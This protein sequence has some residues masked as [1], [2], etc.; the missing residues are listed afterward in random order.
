MRIVNTTISIGDNSYGFTKGAGEMWLLDDVIEIEGISLKSKNSS[1]RGI[2]SLLYFVVAVLIFSSI[3]WF[4]IVPLF[5]DI[6]QQWVGWF[7]EDP[8][9]TAIRLI[10]MVK[11][12][13]GFFFLVVVPLF[14]SFWLSDKIINPLRRLLSSPSKESIPYSAFSGASLSSQIQITSTLHRMEMT[15]STEQEK[16]GG[17]LSVKTKDVSLP[18]GFLFRC[19]EDIQSFSKSVGAELVN[20]ENGTMLKLRFLGKDYLIDEEHIG[21]DD[22]KQHLNTASLIINYLLAFLFNHK[23]KKTFSR[24]PSRIDVRA[25]DKNHFDTMLESLSGMLKGNRSQFRRVAHAIGAKENMSNDKTISMD[26]RA[27]PHVNL[28]LEFTQ[29]WTGS[30]KVELY[31]EE[32]TLDFFGKKFM[33]TICET[34]NNLLI[35]A[36]SREEQT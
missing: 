31:F 30:S 24:N 7:R 23:N 34:L 11:M 36:V 6:M 14:V 10:N 4:L 18:L 16:A 17:S 35:G 3:E 28:L 15:T 21:S 13:C 2:L 20:D 19:I 33:K 5:G 26:V 8:S 25:L 1:L 29:S 22:A 32:G 9:I 12:V 27:F